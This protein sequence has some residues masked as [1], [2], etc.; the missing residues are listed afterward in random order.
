MITKSLTLILFGTLFL[1]IGHFFATA[2]K[3]FIANSDPA[4]LIV[5][6]V[7]AQ[8]IDHGKTAYRPV[9]ALQTKSKPR[10]EY[11]GGPYSTPM[12]HKAGDVVSG[13]YNPKTGV[14]RS[15]AMTHQGNR[16][17]FWAQILGALCIL[18]SVALWF[19]VPSIIGA[20]SGER[21]RGWLQG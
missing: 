21:R 15:D 12:P 8:A 20:S 6:R 3:R 18:Q 11:G 1:V 7:E 19:G 9:Y 10:P 16:M 5:L 13:R 14:M 17:W 2:E 4:T